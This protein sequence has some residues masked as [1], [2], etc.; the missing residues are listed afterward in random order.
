MLACRNIDDEL[1]AS[2][3]QDIGCDTL[4]TVESSSK[5][6]NTNDVFDKLADATEV[7]VAK[8]ENGKSEEI[9]MHSAFFAE[10]DPHEQR[11]E[12]RYPARWIVNGRFGT[13][14]KFTA[15]T[16]DI[17]V[18]GVLMFTS[19]FFKQDQR[20][21]IQMHTYSHGKKKIIDAMVVFKHTS[22]SKNLYRCGA[23]FL[24]ISVP[25]KLF[26]EKYVNGF[27]PHKR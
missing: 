5:H 27:D 19:E 26:L 12:R 4:N 1:V 22:I 2:L 17:S 15:E 21:Y 16:N 3:L 7:Y 18:S 25:N 14:S 20:A 9:T 11:R 24:S 23:E 6:I 8:K 10:K 13:G